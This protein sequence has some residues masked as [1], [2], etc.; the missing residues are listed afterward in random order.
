MNKDIEEKIRERIKLQYPFPPYESQLD[1]SKDIYM[2]LAQGIKVSIFESPTGTGKS[3]ALIEGALN[4]LDDIKSNTLIKVKQKCQIDND[5]PD[6]F[7][8][9]DV[10]LK[11]NPL[12]KPNINGILDF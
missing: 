8:E 9:P 2:S 5:M 12:K 11:L 6:W 10:D 7:N 4:Y 3:Y 1:L